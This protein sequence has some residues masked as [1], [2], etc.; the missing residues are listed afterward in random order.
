MRGVE[1][2]GAASASPAL[3]ACLTSLVLDC[4][5]KTGINSFLREVSHQ[6]TIPVDLLCVVGWR[7]N[8][9][10]LRGPL[11]SLERLTCIFGL[12]VSIFSC[13]LSFGHA[14]G[15]LGGLHPT[16]LSVP[17]L[18]TQVG[19]SFHTFLGPELDHAAITHPPPC[20]PPHPHATGCTS[21]HLS[22][23]LLSPLWWH[24]G[25]ETRLVAQRTSN[26]EWYVILLGTHSPC[27]GLPE[28]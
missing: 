17:G 16:I 27:R 2:G 9:W 14:S 3:L 8:P 4:G 25:H 19:F 22:P 5:G 26:W 11:W 15:A 20:P 12:T 6:W 18:L 1:R 24:P 7:L 21:C 28:R 10:P 13:K 23:E